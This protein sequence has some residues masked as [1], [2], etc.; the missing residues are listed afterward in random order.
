MFRL[1]R[2]L[3]GVLVIS[4]ACAAAANAATMSIAWDPNPE[5]DIA[6]YVVYRGATCSLFTT[7]VDVGNRLS[8]SFTS[9]PD[10]EAHCFA[11]QAYNTAGE[12]SPLSDPVTVPAPPPSTPI[13]W[14]DGPAQEATLKQPFRMSGWAVDTA[15]TVGTGV[16]MMHV[17][18]FPNP[19]S[20][21]PP[22]F[23]GF[24]S[25]G[26][27]RPDVA[28]A[29][30]SSRF[31]NSGFDV[32]VNGLVPGRYMIV[33]FVHST[34]SAAFNSAATLLVNIQAGPLTAIDVP[35]AGLVS[36]PF[37]IDG[38]SIDPSAP[39]GTGVDQVTV[40]AYPVGGGAAVP[41]GTAFYGN[42]RPDVAAVFGARFL[43]SRYQ[44]AI[45][46]LPP[47][48]YDLE[49]R[50]RSTANGQVVPTARVRVTVRGRPVMT[51]DGPANLS[52]L[53]SSFR[54]AGWAIDRE[55]VSGP[56]VDTLHVY[57]FPVSGGG[58]ATFLGVATYGAS[59]PDVAAA[60]G[61][62][63]FTNSGYELLVS[64]LAPGTYDVVVF[65]HSTV[66]ATFSTARVTRVTIR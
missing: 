21:Q 18:A 65:S 43:N 11:V 4:F 57:A 39:T 35:T 10:R 45:D 8:Y 12:R 44:M 51:I 7:I 5:P 15:S 47:G 38:W 24:A 49:V 19:G 30:G 13:N 63:R 32:T 2:V 17:Y 66:T 60:F 36:Q 28:A 27:S 33:A 56:G 23:L 29:F 26:L 37:F 61:N 59:R 20:N 53:T 42:V 48:L 46:T 3:A 25:Y 31:T 54:V 14:I 52:V 62:S 40:F 64:G 34:V 16:D 55:S 50:S 41:V 58:P 9:L 6:G 1:P 22:V